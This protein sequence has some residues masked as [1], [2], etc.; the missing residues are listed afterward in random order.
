MQQKKKKWVRTVSEIH[1]IVDFSSLINKFILE[2]LVPFVA[3]KKYDF[4]IIKRKFYFTKRN[5]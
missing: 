2:W 3:N 5:S 4:F 1:V